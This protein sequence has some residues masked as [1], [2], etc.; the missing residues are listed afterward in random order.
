MNHTIHRPQTAKSEAFFTFAEIFLMLILFCYLLFYAQEALTGV[1]DGLRICLQ[2]VIPALFPFMVVSR[3]FV[4]SGMAK[5]LGTKLSRPFSK[6]F[7][8]NGNGAA[9]LIVGLLSGFPLGAQCAVQLYENNLCSKR[10]TE[11]LLAFCSNTGPSFLIG[12]VGIALWGNEQIGTILFLAQAISALSCGMLFGIF[13]K[14]RSASMNDWQEIEFREDHTAIRLS[15]LP[16]AITESVVPMLNVCA[17]VIVFRIIFLAVSHLLVLWD[18]GVIISSIFACFLE[19]STGVGEAAALQQANPAIAIALTGAA[20]G[21]SG[22]SVHL[23]II[24][25]TAPHRLSL[26]PYVFGK[27]WSIVFT[28]GITYILSK[29]F[30]F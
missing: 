21:W 7:G 22:L 28:A 25:I 14:K 3:I 16:D 6:L 13:C 8:I 30:L 26:K 19:V 9:A 23:Q 17:F 27:I 24:A 20:I 1:T 2:R 18:A 10:E 29:I 11:Y 4:T 5:K 15:L 12:S